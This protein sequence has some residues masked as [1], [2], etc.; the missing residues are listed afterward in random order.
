MPSE[1]TEQDHR[2]ATLRASIAARFRKEFE[3]ALAL[4]EIALGPGWEPISTHSLV[5][6][7]EADAAR[8]ENRRMTPAVVVYTATKDGMKRHFM[9]RDGH[10]VEVASVEE[11][12]GPMLTEADLDRTIEVK[13]QRVALHRYGLYWSGFEKDYRPQSAEQLA[14]ARS[15]REARS[16]EKEADGSLFADLIRQEG[17]E[18]RQG[19]PR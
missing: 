10:S 14:M 18:P 19:K 13:G 16:V 3:D 6:L 8:Q 5:E 1:P 2:N 12:F 7:Q 15:R 9:V 11:G 4:S 17:Y